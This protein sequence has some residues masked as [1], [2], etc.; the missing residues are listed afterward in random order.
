MAK[1]ACAFVDQAFGSIVNA[2]IRQSENVN[3]TRL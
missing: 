1:Y 3:S 2:L